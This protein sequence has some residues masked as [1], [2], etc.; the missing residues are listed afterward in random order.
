VLDTIEQEEFA[1]L[2]F[3]SF[4]SLLGVPLMVIEKAKKNHAN[5][6]KASPPTSPST[7]APS[8]SSS[9][10]TATGGMMQRP[11]S[12]HSRHGCPAD[13]SKEQPFSDVLH[14]FDTVSA[15]V[16][17]GVSEAKRY[18]NYMKKLAKAKEAYAKA[19]TDITSEEMSKGRAAEDKMRR[20]VRGFASFKQSVFDEA[21]AEAKFAKA[22]MTSVVE[23]ME[24]AIKQL[25]LSRTHTHAQSKH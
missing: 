2:D 25:E 6:T 5:A 17:V 14:S 13:Y 12:L 8:F 1:S 23:P 7:H 9:S 20:G 18:V 21:S 19:I 4:A 16:D 11:S 22:V 24:T 10:S 15:Q 3:F